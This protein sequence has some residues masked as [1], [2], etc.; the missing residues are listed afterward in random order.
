MLHLVSI[1]FL[2]NL[3][4]LDNVLSPPSFK[5]VSQFFTLPILVALLSFSPCQ[6]T[7]A[8]KTPPLRIKAG[9]EWTVDFT[10]NQGVD[11]FTFKL[12][13]KDGGDGQMTIS[14]WPVP[15]G[16][17]QIASSI[18]LM[19]D[20]FIETAKGNP[21]L[22]LKENKVKIEKIKGGEVEGEAA[23]FELKLEIFQTMFMF[24]D[25]TQT[26]NGQFTGSKDGWKKAKNL[27]EQITKAPKAKKP[28]AK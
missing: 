15:G 25:G 12:N 7:K 1:P 8:K 6:A 27:L 24:N 22:Q 3:N 14:R 18:Q 10:N 4:E 28:K 11:F 9:L 23:I 5:R 19:A 20:S 26:W 16:V 2:K 13:P 21:N 17:E